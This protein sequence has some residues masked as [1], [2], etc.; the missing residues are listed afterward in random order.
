MLAGTMCA[1]A[2]SLGA[3]LVQEW[4]ALTKNTLFLIES[5]VALSFYLYWFAHT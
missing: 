5:T 1:L 4:K 3:R 2:P